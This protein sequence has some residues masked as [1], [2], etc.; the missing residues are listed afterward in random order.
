VNDR[1][2]AQ[3][4]LVASAVL[5]GALLFIAAF[6]VARN[7][8][9]DEIGLFNPVYMK[10]HYGVMTYPIHGYFGG[11][12]VHPP[13]HYSMIAALMRA[14]VPLYYAEA[15]P[16]FVMALVVLLLVLRAPFAP[17][18]KL[19]LIC[20]LYSITAFFTWRDSDWELFGTRPDYHASLAWLGALVL[21]ESARLSRWHRASLFAGA[22]LLAYACGLHY[23]T[24]PAGLALVVY[25]VAAIAT[26]GWRG[27]AGPLVAMGAGA[28]VVGVPYLLMFV[29][30][31]WQDIG[32]I[33][34]Q[35][36]G[37][38]GVAKAFAL[39]L[40]QYRWWLT[41]GGGVWWMRVLFAAGVPLSV[42]STALLWIAFPGVR[43][44]T[45]AAVPLQ[46]YLLLFARHK[47]RAYYAPELELYVAAVIGASVCTC[48][49]L[50][51]KWSMPRVER[52]VLPAA[53]VLFFVLSPHP[54]DIVRAVTT[55]APDV[56]EME[57]AR[58]SAQAML[59]PGARVGGH[60]GLWYASGAEHWYRID[61]DLFWARHVP[62]ADLPAYFARFDAMAEATHASNETQND[63][64]AT[65][66][67]WYADGTL[68]LRGF[69]FAATNAEL[70]YVLLSGAAP[71]RLAGYIMSG[72]DLMR[73]DASPGGD[74]QLIAAS[75]VHPGERAARLL[76]DA[77]AGVQLFLPNSLTQYVFTT[78]LPARRAAAVDLGS[79][80]TA[81]LTARGTTSRV[82][83]DALLAAHR[84][85]NAVVRFYD[86]LQNVPGRDGRPQ[87]LGAVPEV[88]TVRSPGAIRLDGIAPS[89]ANGRVERGAVARVGLDPGMGGFAAA[90][91]IVAPG[92]VAGECWIRARLNV[93]RGQVA[94]G[95]FDTK[96]KAF[97][98]ES[99][100]ITKTGQALDVYLHLPS[101]SGVDQLILR[102]A[103]DVASSDVTIESVELLLP[104]TANPGPPHGSRH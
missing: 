13:L 31:H 96:R 84:R 49:T 85:T 5:V 60:L 78:V 67:S 86:N 99:P 22:L 40:E 46:C 98:A 58:A 26:L 90:V 35:V 92:N 21:L 29:L 30:P 69:Y 65:L 80:C 16:T 91:P 18:L 11:M 74:Q 82:D 3:Y 81:F 24:A 100:V 73:F 56:H 83:R 41:E 9:V 20:S 71:E 76:H 68:R 63:Q 93:L 59:G 47:H 101:L 62:R 12:F 77:G 42:V 7:G 104:Q 75:C 50:A 2:I 6:R 10:V 25:G 95:A 97:V 88:A 1:K 19:G 52:L 39:H 8:G 54:S 87:P 28:A 53:A 55:T 57:F 27:S 38:G 45:L 61:P 51:K 48:A 66:S 94:I 17:A 33:V 102:S 44:L 37:G 34:S 103:S 72:R 4:A 89:Y 43:V 64:G 15:A 36:Q 23:I 70:S 14:G 79:E 32:L